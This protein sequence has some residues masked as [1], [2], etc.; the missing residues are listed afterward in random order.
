MLVRSASGASDATRFRRFVHADAFT[1]ERGLVGA[2]AVRLDKARVGGHFL[3][4]CQYE[5]VTRHNFI[6]IHL[7]T[8]AV[9][10]HAALKTR[11]LSSASSSF[12]ARY[13]SK[14]LKTTLSAMMPRIKNAVRRRPLSPG[15]KLTP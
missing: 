12:C 1:C 14:K 5:H 8:D 2:Q 10:D 6:G 4:V 11:S 15:K 9:A 3:P 13:S 7:P